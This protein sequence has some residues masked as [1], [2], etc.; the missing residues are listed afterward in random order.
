[1]Q[2]GGYELVGLDTCM[3]YSKILLS[4][5]CE[6]LQGRRL[7]VAW[8]LGQGESL[9]GSGASWNSSDSLTT[10]GAL[11]GRRKSVASSLKKSSSVS[12]LS[13]RSFVSCQRVVD[14]G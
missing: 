11:S 9:S 7:C 1:M 14:S 2:R 12:G 5:L 4:S 13:L 8:N 3:S 10:K 6:T